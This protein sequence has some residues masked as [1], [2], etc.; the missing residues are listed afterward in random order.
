M[1]TVAVFQ[2]ICMQLYTLLYSTPL[3]GP[4]SVYIAVM[5][6][7]LGWWCTCRVRVFCLIH[8]CTNTYM[9]TKWP[10]TQN[11]LR[12]V[13]LDAVYMYCTC[14]CVILVWDWWNLQVHKCAQLVVASTLESCSNRT[15][16]KPMISPYRYGK[17]NGL[18]GEVIGLNGEV[19]G[20][21]G[22]VMAL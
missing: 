8:T 14:T 3:M 17:A 10:G 4:S 16:C 18:N 2:C 7:L 1:H 13:R 20:L 22:K 6:C 5:V 21:H 15:Y 9:Y 19:I 12:Y 11:T